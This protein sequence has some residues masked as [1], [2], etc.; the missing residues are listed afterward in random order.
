VRTSPATPARLEVPPAAEVR[1][2]PGYHARTE[3]RHAPAGVSTFFLIPATES[4]GRT[5]DHRATVEA[6]GG[7][8]L[9]LEERQCQN[10]PFCA[11]H[12]P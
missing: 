9:L 5:S 10:T 3:V 7:P 11:T 6:A 4:Q 12:L 2:I 1:T 8:A